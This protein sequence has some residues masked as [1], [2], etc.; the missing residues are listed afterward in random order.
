MNKIPRSIAVVGGGTAGFVSALIL[1]KRYPAFKIDVIRSK[2]IGIV[3]VGEGSTEHWREFINFIGVDPHT[4]IQECDA[5][6]KCGIMFQNWGVPD[7]CHSIQTE[8]N[9]KLGQYP[10]V[11]GKL[12]GD[13]CPPQALMT[14]HYWNSRI[15]QLFLSNPDQGPTNQ[16][17]FNTNKLNSFLTN[18]ASDAG[19]KVYD[20]EI[21][22][23]DINENGDI[24][25]LYGNKQSYNYDFYIDSTGFKKLL[26]SKLGAKWQ[27]Y[28]KYL[29]MNSAIAFPTGDTENYNMWTLA[30]GMDSGWLFR[31]PVW[32]RHGNGYIFNSDFITVDKAKEEVEKLYGHEIEIGK[33]ITFDPGAL[34]KVWINNCCAIGL[35]AS[36]VEPLEASSI[37]S[38]IQQAFLLMHRIINYNQKVIDLYNEDCASILENIRDFV[39][40]HYVTKRNDT[41]FWKSLKDVPLPDSLAEKVE[42]WRDRLPIEEDFNKISK[43][44]LFKDPHHMFIM[45]GLGLFNTA[46]IKSEFES[47]N[48]VKKLEAEAIIRNEILR[49]DT[50]PTFT[51]KETLQIIRNNGK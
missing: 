32:G 22:N 3:G 17:H 30:R 19:I 48:I 38:S 25:T 9:V 14:R 21:E 28:K 13:N 5:T 44:A 45:H 46:S 37:G 23:F 4:I 20:D 15:N 43:Y 40:L 26:I 33:H 10:Y 29:K 24:T 6:Y 49:D 50:V 41:D 11:Y 31:I 8:M 42:M 12:I 27:S 51:H 16:F 35:S 39:A 7:Y 1:K 34:D 36:F 47:Q 18:Q 2:K